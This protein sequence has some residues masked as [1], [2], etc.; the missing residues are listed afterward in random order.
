MVDHV[1]IARD[2]F[3]RLFAHGPDAIAPLLAADADWL[4]ADPDPWVCTGRDQILG[5]LRQA[6]T[7]GNVTT[8]VDCSGLGDHVIAHLSTRS[9]EGDVRDHYSAVTFRGDEVVRIKDWTTEGEARRSLTTVP[10]SA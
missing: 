7:Q 1:A 9:S 2:G 3:A 4:S 8:L 10:G 6:F 5:R